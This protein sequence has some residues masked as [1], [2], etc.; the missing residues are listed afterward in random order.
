MEQENL[1]ITNL[2]YYEII[3]NISCK[4]NYLQEI[5]MQN[6]A[7]IILENGD[8][9]EFIEDNMIIFENPKD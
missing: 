9:I 7:D 8:A 5:V 2:M 3:L 6:I 1:D 4:E